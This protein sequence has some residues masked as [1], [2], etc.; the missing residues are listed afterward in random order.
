[1]I[2][3]KDVILALGEKI[4]HSYY[5]KGD[6][7]LLLSHMDDDILFVGGG[8]HISCEAMPMYRA[9]LLIVRRNF[10]PAILIITVLP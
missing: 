10:S 1:M 5:E 6:I 2:K 8:R 7:E 9:C 4:L 3:D